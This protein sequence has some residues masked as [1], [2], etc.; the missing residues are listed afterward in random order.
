MTSKCYFESSL[1]IEGGKEQK[2]R[3]REGSE[4]GVSSAEEGKVVLEGTARSKSP[5]GYRRDAEII[6]K[7]IRAGMSCRRGRWK[8]REED[9]PNFLVELHPS[10]SPF[11]LS[12]ASL[13]LS[14]YTPFFLVSIAP[15]LIV[16]PILVSEPQADFVSRSLP[17]FPSS[18]VAETSLSPSSTSQTQISTRSTTERSQNRSA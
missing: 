17:A 6:H 8:Q 12:S 14:L 3:G 2:G 13:R 16:L 5:I 11:L 1:G 10:P 7:G 9:V 18:S 15:S 4:E